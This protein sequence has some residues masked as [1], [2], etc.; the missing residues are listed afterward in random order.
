MPSKASRLH[1]SQP[2]KSASLASPANQLDELN[3][4]KQLVLARHAPPTG[5]VRLH[6]SPVPQQDLP[7]HSA[8]A[9]DSKRVERSDDG[10]Q[11]YALGV[12]ARLRKQANT[13][14]FKKTV[15]DFQRAHPELSAEQITAKLQLQSAS[16]LMQAVREENE[17][18][19]SDSLSRVR[20]AS[21]FEGFMVNLITQHQGQAGT[22]DIPALL[23]KAASTESQTVAQEQDRAY[24]QGLQLK[25]IPMLR[26]KSF[27]AWTDQALEQLPPHSS[28]DLA[29]ALVAIG[30]ITGT[31]ESDS[32]MISP[33]QMNPR[34][35]RFVTPFC[36]SLI[37]LLRDS[38]GFSVRVKVAMDEVPSIT[39]TVAQETAVQHLII[40]V[41]RSMLKRQDFLSLANS[42]NSR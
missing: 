18:S 36:K 16:A 9:I 14:E 8:A 17:G 19:E 6:L 3:K 23:E 24:A 15:N 1:K 30:A 39:R 4:L 33:S 5:E 21:E 22:L 20:P 7:S 35:E 37:T 26:T 13:P 29:Q 2:A 11:I 34:D 31:L 28:V 40:E 42:L 41:L 32:D 12:A 25:L 27:E 10:A 38:V